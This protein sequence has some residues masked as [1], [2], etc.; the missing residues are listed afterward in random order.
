MYMQAKKP[1][2]TPLVLMLLLVNL[3]GRDLR[4]EKGLRALVWSLL[5]SSNII[6]RNNMRKVGAVTGYKSSSVTD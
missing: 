2:Q 1:A 4:Q 5:M 3:T 6:E